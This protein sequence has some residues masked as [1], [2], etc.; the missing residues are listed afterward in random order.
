WRRIGGGPGLS[1]YLQS[2]GFPGIVP[3]N[4]DFWGTSTASANS[5]TTVVARMLFGDAYRD[6]HRKLALT[7]MTS[8]VSAERGGVAAR[9]RTTGGDTIALK[10]GWYPDDNGWR[11]NSV[12][13]VLPSDSSRHPYVIAVL[14]NRQPSFDYGIATIEGIAQRIGQ[15]MGS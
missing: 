7:L 15:A 4:G 1:A 9:G 3:Y 2:A 13:I 6:E 5:M 8:V 12:G 11:V 10:D 14:S